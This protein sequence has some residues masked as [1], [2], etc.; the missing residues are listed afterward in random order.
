M[1]RGP[2]LGASGGAEGSSKVPGAPGGA[3]L[4]DMLV[5][6][7]QQMLEQEAPRV[8]VAGQRLTVQRTRAQHL[9]F[10]EFLYDGRSI[11]GIEQNPNTASRWA[12]LA[13]EGHRIVQ[14]RCGR[15]YIAN[16]CDGTLLRYPRWKG[17]G[18]PD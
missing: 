9:R 8:E 5:S 17:L 12:K 10:V 18:L 1:A 14:F 16:V 3:A 6:I 11:E 7:W 2:V 13:Q 4:S 15:Q